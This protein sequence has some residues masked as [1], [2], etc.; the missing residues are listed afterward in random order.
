MAFEIPSFT[1]GTQTAGEDYSAAGKSSVF[2]KIDTDGRIVH[3]GSGATVHGVV[4]NAPA[5]D[6]PVEFVVSGVARVRAG[7]A[8]GTPGI[9]LMSDGNGKAVT[10]TSTNFAA[11]ISL[12]AVAAED[13]FVTVLLLGPYHRALA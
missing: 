7:A 13:E 8:I 9:L 12:D 10:A 2:G 11:G 4:N 1:L 5:T 6:Q 3:T